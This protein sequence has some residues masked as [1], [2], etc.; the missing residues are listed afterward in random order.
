MWLKAC[1]DTANFTETKKLLL[2]VLYIKV[3]ISWN[4]TVGSLIVP[5]STIKPMNSRK[6]KLN[7]IIIFIF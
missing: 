2:K 7:S 5:K 1:L 4:S 3:K 6:N